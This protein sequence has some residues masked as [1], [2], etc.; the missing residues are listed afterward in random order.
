MGYQLSGIY[1]TN[2]GVRV[3]GFLGGE[4][5]SRFTH[6]LH[7]SSFLGLP[8]PYRILKRNHK[9]ELQWSL[10]VGL[11]ASSGFKCLGLRVSGLGVSWARA[12]A[13]VFMA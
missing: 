2:L 9:K 8:Y 7:G 4:G 11:T 10:W 5:G 12:E 1:C 6:R 3:E 13:L